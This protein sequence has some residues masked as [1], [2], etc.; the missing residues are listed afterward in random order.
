MN[1][2]RA[3]L[4]IDEGTLL[5]KNDIVRA[6]ETLDAVTYRYIV[7]DEPVASG[8]GWVVRIYHGTDAATLVVNDCLFLNANS[9]DYAKFTRNDAGRTVIELHA[10]TKLLVLEPRD[11][12]DAARMA[13]LIN[14]VRL[15]DEEYC[16]Y[17]TEESGGDE[18]GY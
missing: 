6:L 4:I 12:E 10:D 13:R 9:F 18:E 17:Y 14:R 2:N 16:P 3:P 7:D 8:S 15:R 11:D 5:R 1:R